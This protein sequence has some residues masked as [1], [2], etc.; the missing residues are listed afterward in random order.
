M[1]HC[2]TLDFA[3]VGG[4]FVVDFSLAPFLSYP[5]VLSRQPFL[6]H[7][8]LLSLIFRSV[9]GLYQLSK[10][11]SNLNLHEELYA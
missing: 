7:F 8:L 1:I 10:G 4:D 6:Y 5:V 3:L 2:V 9:L 11:W